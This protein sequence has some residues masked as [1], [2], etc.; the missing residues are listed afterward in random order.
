M[1]ERTWTAD[2]IDGMIARAAAAERNKVAVW[3]MAKGYATGHGDTIEDLL[4]EVAWQTRESELNACC[5]LLE[6]M[7]AVSTDRHNYWLH[8][9]NEL[10]RLRGKP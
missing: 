10:R 8:A 2:E 5:D 1:N 3:L 4:N 9:A 7:H 6:G